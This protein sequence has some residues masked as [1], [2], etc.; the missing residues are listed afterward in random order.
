MVGSCAAVTLKSTVL[1]FSKHIQTDFR[2]APGWVLRHMEGVRH[3][4]RRVE[5][6][7]DDVEQIESSDWLH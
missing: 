1:V 5:I 7:A 3:F 4:E 6:N 2:V